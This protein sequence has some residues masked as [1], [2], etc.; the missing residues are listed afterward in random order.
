MGFRIQGVGMHGAIAGSIGVVGYLALFAGIGLLFVFVNLLIGRF[1][2]PKNPH[3]EKLDIYECGE[4]TIGSSFVQFDLRF[5]VIALIFIVFDVEVAFLFPWATVFGKANH[6]VAASQLETSSALAAV[7]GL[8]QELGLPISV[9]PVG[10]PAQAREGGG[11]LMRLAVIEVLVFFVILLV[12]YIYLW[13][14]GALDWVRATMEREPEQLAT[15]VSAA[16]T[17]S[18]S[19]VLSA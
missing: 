3:P 18:T 15:K 12:G 14:T 7:E 13:G 6:L 16:R 2:R 17:G 1:L 4:P 9:I 10:T 19:P 8:H 11:L 5:Y